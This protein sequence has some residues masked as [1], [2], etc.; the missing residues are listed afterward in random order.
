MDVVLVNMK[1]NF[2]VYL[3]SGIHFTSNLTFSISICYPLSVP[4]ENCS[5]RNKQTSKETQNK[6]CETETHR[7]IFQA[8]VI[9]TELINSATRENI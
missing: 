8:V 6:N 5:Q 7:N 1:N 9:S 3:I 4:S 2:I